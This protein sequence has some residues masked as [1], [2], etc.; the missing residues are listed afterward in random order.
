MPLEKKPFK[1]YGDNSKNKPMPVKLNE[2]DE[3]MLAHAM[4]A[5]NI[6][7]KSGVLKF[8]AHW[9][10]RKVILDGL[11]VEE[12]HYLTRSD[13]TKIVH[14]DVPYRHFNKKGI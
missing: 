6:H 7:S 13:R 12:F 3:E 5:L 8:L 10:F 11:S 14:E 1:N 9:G 2:K 4:Y